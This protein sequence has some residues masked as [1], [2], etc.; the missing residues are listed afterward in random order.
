M[1]ND[2]NIAHNTIRVSFGRDN[3]IEEVEALIKNLEAIIKE[4]KQ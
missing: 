2:L 4:I 1:T 3:T